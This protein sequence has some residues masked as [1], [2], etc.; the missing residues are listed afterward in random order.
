MAVKKQTIIRSSKREG[1]GGLG[2]G[3]KIGFTLCFIRYQD[4]YLMLHRK[5]APNKNKWN[6]VG[7]KIEPG[8]SPEQACIR[9]IYE[10]TGLRILSL[11][12]RGIVYWNN[13]GGMYVFLAESPT[14]QLVSSEEGKLEW[15]SLEWV[16]NCPDVASNIPLFLAVMLD[17]D[18]RPLQHSFFYNEQGEIREYNIEELLDVYVGEKE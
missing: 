15:K 8:E 10:E 2:M 17:T 5:K 16:Q 18:K 11:T 12:F 13:E 6:G 7:G 14:A 1:I 4:N 3:I 9:E